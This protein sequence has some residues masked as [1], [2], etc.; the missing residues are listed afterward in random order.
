MNSKTLDKK[1]LIAGVLLLVSVRLWLVP[2]SLGGGS[3]SLTNIIADPSSAMLAGAVAI[4]GITLLFRKRIIAVIG[5][6]VLAAYFAY[7]L[8]T[9]NAFETL[10]WVKEVCFIAG[11]ILAAIGIFFAD[12][13][14]AFIQILRGLAIAAFIAWWFFTYLPGIAE[15][16]YAS[17]E[18]LEAIIGMLRNDLLVIGLSLAAASTFENVD[19]V[20]DE[21]FHF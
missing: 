14:N 10:A 3:A 13:D 20:E 5:L 9:G 6:I 19:E 1:A 15:D 7:T 21:E 12:S 4:A 16:T 18:T 8:V 11:I 17:M 2:I